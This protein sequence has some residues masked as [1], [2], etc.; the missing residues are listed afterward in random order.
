LYHRLDVTKDDCAHYQEDAMTSY[1]DEMTLREARTR[2]FQDNQFGEDGGY[3]EDWV[4]FKLGP[5]PMPF[6]N[7]QG[8]LRAVRVHDLHHIVTGYATDTLGEFEISAWEIGA[9]CKD[10]WAAWQLNL[11]G[12]A[13]G[14]LVAPGRIH[15]AFARGLASRSLYGEDIEAQLDRT[16]GEVRAE[17]LADT[18]AGGGRVAA[19]FLVT[20]AVGV[21]VALGFGALVIPLVPVGLAVAAMRSRAA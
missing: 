11:A 5:I 21:V 15:R 4:N 12:M 6:P 9:G 8:R 1:P 10:F 14:A 3:G 7:T 17:R 18:P 16:V 19:L 13:T 2:Y 20:T